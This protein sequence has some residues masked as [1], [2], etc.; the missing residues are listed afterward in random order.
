MD[1]DFKVRK[2]SY[3][4]KEQRS[5]LYSVRSYPDVKRILVKGRP[6]HISPQN[7][8]ILTTSDSDYIFANNNI[9]EINDAIKRLISTRGRN[10]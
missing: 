7:K 5:G 10:R 2:V 3:I 9:S 8:F 1:F 6:L 4:C